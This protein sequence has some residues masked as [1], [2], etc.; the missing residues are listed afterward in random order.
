[1]SIGKSLLKFRRKLLPL[2]AEPRSPRRG[3]DTEG[4]G[5]AILRNVGSYLP[6]DTA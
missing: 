6:V 3:P 2:S 5:V 1:V 4:R